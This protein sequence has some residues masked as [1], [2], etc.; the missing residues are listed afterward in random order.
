MR[1]HQCSP[2]GRGSY[3]VMLVG[4]TT[5]VIKHGKPEL[6]QPLH[7]LHCQCWEGGGVPQDKQDATM[8]TVY[9]NKGNHRTAATTGESSSWALLATCMSTSSSTHCVWTKRPS[10]SCSTWHNCAWG[11]WSG[12]YL[13][14]RYSS[15][16]AQVLLPTTR[17][18][19]K[20]WVMHTSSLSMLSAWRRQTSVHMVPPLVS[21]NRGQL[22]LPGIHHQQHQLV[23]GKY[24]HG[25]TDKD[26]FGI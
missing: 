26:G 20:D 10:Q 13:T 9:K 17:M 11:P 21:W 19:F 24:H 25:Q 12:W 14:G 15:P 16:T 3:A 2:N 23:E 5:E 4:N 6:H 7:E 1:Y 8:M 18:P 22:Y